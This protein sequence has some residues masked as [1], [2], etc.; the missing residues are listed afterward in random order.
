VIKKK[1]KRPRFYQ[2]QFEYQRPQYYIMKSPLIPLWF[3]SF[4]VL[5]NSAK[6]GVL[7]P[8]YS[9]NHSDSVLAG[10]LKKEKASSLLP[11]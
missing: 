2:P 1:R 9:R 7:V 5:E 6:G 10:D 11:K 3:S 4:I 8:N